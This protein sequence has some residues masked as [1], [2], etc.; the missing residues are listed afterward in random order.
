M[1]SL[2]V[3][4]SKTSVRPGES[5]T[6]TAKVK[7][8]K[9]TAQETRLSVNA[10]DVTVKPGSVALGTVGAAGRTAR[11]TVRVPADARPGT[12]KLTAKVTAAKAE[13][14]SRTF[15]F[16]VTEAPS[17][18]SGSNSNA[19][20]GTSLPTAAVP[21]V[22]PLPNSSFQ[23][24]PAIRAPQVALPPVSAP[25][26]APSP[27]PLTPVAGLR[28]VP[29]DGWDT[30]DLAAV[31]AGWLA[32]LTSTGAIVFVRVRV[33]RRRR[34]VRRARHLYA[35]KRLTASRLRTLPPQPS[36]RVRRRAF[37]G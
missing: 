29:D 18:G 26:T 6:A 7:A 31:Q 35:G 24:V 4:V 17:S 22:A 25:Q 30:G 21:Q 14:V 16:K 2:G 19:G 10:A 15:T 5:V 27:E 33:A 9:A 8:A 32:A 36:G 12:V 3:S 28:A 23:S 20:S 37:S 34:D 1:L 13:P 11:V